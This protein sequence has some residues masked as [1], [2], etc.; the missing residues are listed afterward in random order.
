MKLPASSQLLP[1][2]PLLILSVPLALRLQ[3]PQIL[4]Q[5]KLVLLGNISGLM[6]SEGLSLSH[7]QGLP[8]WIGTVA[9]FFLSAFGAGCHVER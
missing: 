5:M 9:C 1:P 6:C 8:S 3:L 7:G 4:L 2:K